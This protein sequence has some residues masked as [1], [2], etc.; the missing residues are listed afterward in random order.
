MNRLLE[1]SISRS[2]LALVAVVLVCLDVQAAQSKLLSATDLEFFE[3]RIR[4]VLTTAC[5]SCH[6]RESEKIKGGLLLDSLEGLMKGGEGGAVVVPGKPDK[7]RLIEAV[8]WTNADFQMPPKKA[9]RP[10]QIE[11]LAQWVAMGA[12]WPAGESAA[13]ARKR[14]LEITDK[15]RQHWAFR[16]VT[17]PATP[18]ISGVGVGR[19]PIDAFIGAKLEAKGLKPAE[20]ASKRTLI[21]RLYYDLIGLPPSPE[22]VELF[23]A[24][25]SPDVW[26]NLVDR[27]L[28]SSHYGEHWG[29]H[30]LDLVRFAETNSYERD[31]AKPHAWRYRDYVIRAFNADKPFDRFV[32]EQLAGDELP[33]SGD[34]GVIATGYY[35]LGIWDDEPADR[36]LARF[37]ML[38]DIVATTG[39]VFLGLTIDCARC[40][41]H[42]IDP[43]TQRDYYSLLSFFHNVSHYKNGGPTDEVPLRGEGQPL[44]Q[45]DR[46]VSAGSGKKKADEAKIPKALAVTETGAKPPDTFV[47][48]RGSPENKGD[49]VSPAFLEVL[50]PL[51]PQVVPPTHIASTGR[52][53]A[54]ANWIASPANPLT[55]R[56][57]V[58]RV[59]QWH[60][61]RGLVRTPS[62]FGVQG[63]APTHPELLDW[64]SA[65]FVE[66]GWSL[67]ALHRMILTSEAYRRSSRPT[68][69][70]L[71]ADPAND[72]LA[73]F[74]MRRLRAEEIRDS[75]IQ[76][77]GPMN[78]RMHGPGIYVTIPKEVLAGQ[79]VPGSGWGNSPADEQLRRSVYIHVKRSLLTP[80]LLGFDLAEPDR[81]TPARFATTQPTQA[82]GMLNS[83][84]LNDLAARL[85]DRIQ[86]ENY[87]TPADQ[88][89]R[90]LSLVTSRP[91]TDAEIRRGVQFMESLRRDESA[92]DRVALVSFCLLTLNLNEFLYL[93]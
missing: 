72:L 19:N 54:L 74:D 89:R 20:R 65:E 93:D 12:P 26:E 86:Q 28:A 87:R 76:V 75:L 45:G 27:L 21:R 41:D 42:K 38:D 18:Q 46:E 78:T 17:R 67:K 15:D 68:P 22:E 37:D 92:D 16:A 52:R 6:S 49:R 1:E 25:A 13:P 44:I 64:L 4:P 63:Q 8:R 51:Q 31:G 57:L 43:I 11:D 90:A 7:S 59:W 3:K 9:L 58:N 10:D 82:L 5:A 61:G 48:L 30:W 60:F 14:G 32:R 73:R 34:D 23:V 33:D 84:W 71:K 83:T 35:R 62:D 80:I 91:P 88:V 77:T 24:D 79:S 56:V 53:L 40:H 29:R 39:Q 36:E 50:S 85:A 81:S 2:A 55:P 69:E 66:Q 70:A 47:L